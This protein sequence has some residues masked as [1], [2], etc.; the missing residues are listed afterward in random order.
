MQSKYVRAALT[1]A[2]LSFVGLTLSACG[3]DP[4]QILGGGAQ[5]GGGGIL[6]MLVSKVLPLVLGTT[7][8]GGAAAAGIPVVLELIR[9]MKNRN[10][11]AQIENSDSLIDAIFKRAPDAAQVSGDVREGVDM[12][13]G[14]FGDRIASLGI[15]D[16]AL[17]LLVQSAKARNATPTQ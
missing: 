8:V 6:E 5:A 11:K 17:K 1:V 16:E 12:L 9:N 15:T 4:G 13:K 2:V 14:I 10:E 7:G 3:G